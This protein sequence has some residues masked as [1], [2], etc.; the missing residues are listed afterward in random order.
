MPNNN[1][2]KKKSKLTNKLYNLPYDRFWL[3]ST[4][5][6][7]FFI[8]PV[9][10]KIKI[11]LCVGSTN[12][13]PFVEGEK[14]KMHHSSPINPSVHLANING[15]DIFVSWSRYAGDQ[16]MMGAKEHQGKTSTP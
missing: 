14:K 12:P 2:K 8:S 3:F 11:S 13:S 16:Q 5:Y 9:V 10:S 6:E 7:L 15:R 1:N 4:C